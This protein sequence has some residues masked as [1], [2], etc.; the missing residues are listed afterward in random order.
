[1]AD[2]RCL[3]GAVR[4]Q[5]DP[6]FQFMVHCHCSM[7][8][9]HHGSTFATLVAVPPAAFRWVSGEAN[10]GSYVS[11]EHATRTFCRVCG[12][13]APHLLPK[14]GQVILPAG[15]LEGELG[16]T[17]QLHLFAGSKA[18][19][20]E[21]S[22]G[23]PQTE[24][25]PPGFDAMSVARP[26]VPPR[27]GIAEGSCLCGDVAFEIAAA[28]ITMRNCH[29]SRCRRGRSAAHATNVLYPSEAFRWTR[30][31]SQVADFP[32]PDARY[33]GTAFCRRCGA[34]LPRLSRERGMAVVPAGSLDVDPGVRPSGHIYAGS[35]A[36]WFEIT[37]DIPQFDEGP[38]PR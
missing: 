5:A 12:S 32:L 28:P 36:A 9:K 29:C 4:Y 21:I 2:G 26:T 24:E 18:P 31:E 10:V 19:W 7:C 23:L 30:G 35:K 37:D 33:F 14:L 6:P 3:C 25:Y 1:M 11:S 38:P 13:V 34:G 15:N 16:V 20:H 8:R 17:P 22:D 27:P